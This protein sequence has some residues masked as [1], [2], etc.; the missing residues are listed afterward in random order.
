MKIQLKV[1]SELE[2][3]SDIVLVL[4]PSSLLHRSKVRGRERTV[5]R[6]PTVTRTSLRTAV[7]FC[8]ALLTPG[9][10]ITVVLLVYSGSKKYFGTLDV[11]ALDMKTFTS[12]FSFGKSS[13]ISLQMLHGLCHF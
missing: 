3:C 13:S 5:C 12:N 11:I 10:K 1:E 2:G 4:S 6:T 7:R 8:V 9:R